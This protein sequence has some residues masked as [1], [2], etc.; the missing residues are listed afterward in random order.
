MKSP[1]SS[2]ENPDSQSPFA[3]L[4]SLRESL[5]EHPL[6]ARL[7]TLPALQVFMQAH[8]FAVWDFMSLLKALQRALTCVEVPWLPVP[9][10]R[11]ARLLNEI[12]L[13]EESDLTE[14]GEAICHFDLYLRAMREAGADTTTTETFMDK[15]RDRMPLDAA[16]TAA[17]IPDYVQLFV[18]QT[19]TV[20][21]GGKLHEI[22]AAFTYGR[23]DL[24]PSLF[25]GIVARVDEVSQ[26]RLRLM[27]YYLQRHIEL[28]GDEHGALGR[29]MVDLLCAGKPELQREAFEAAATALRSRIKLWDG[30][31]SQLEASGSSK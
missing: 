26:G 15:L 18:R 7:D 1:D 23:E 8:V 27:R 31:V 12:V 6:Y 11:L 25:G 13:G 9:E 22:A 2:A 16:L 24:I 3:E 4:N 30:I 10:P 20:I 29:E 5:L 28:D 17:G 19:F 14:E 21:E